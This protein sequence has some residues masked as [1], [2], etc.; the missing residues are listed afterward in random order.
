MEFLAKALLSMAFNTFA[1]LL[2]SY[3]E[4]NFFIKTDV[5]NLL[6]LIALLTAMNLIVRPALKIVFS[7]VIGL[8]LGLFNIVIAAGI[9]YSID[10]F[11]DSITINGLWSLLVG[12]HVLALIVTLIDYA[13][14]IVYGSGEI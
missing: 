11:S 10:I 3:L 7:P 5:Q 4:P 9:L 2:T 1:L 12:A 14:A 8:T 6:P 13:S